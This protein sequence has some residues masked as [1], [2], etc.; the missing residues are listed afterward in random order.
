VAPSKA[1]DAGSGDGGALPSLS[2]T[3]GMRPNAYADLARGVFDSAGN[4]YAAWMEDGDNNTGIGGT[5]SGS[6]Q[7]AIYFTRLDL[8]AGGMPTPLAQNV[9]V[10]GAKDAVNFDGP[11]IAVAPDGSVT[12]VSYVV[13]V[14]DAVDVV[15][16]TSNDRGA[17]WSPAVKVNDDA[18]CATHFHSSLLLDS[19]GRLYVFFYDNRDG[20]GHFFYSVSD[21]GGK[22][23]HPNRLVSSPSFPFDTFQYSTGWLGDYFEPTVAQG[24]IYVLWSDGRES[25][26]SHAFFAK[27]TLP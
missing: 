22:T 1:G 11:S 27:A 12:Y 9:Q 24:E 8:G 17:T 26:Q 5:L 21:D 10:S 16:A 13:G 15:V 23:F 19:R 25:D 2:L 6:L 4:Y 20:L 7:N 14:N 18:P 3:D